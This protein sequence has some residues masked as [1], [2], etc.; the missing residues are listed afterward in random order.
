MAGLAQHVCCRAGVVD[1]GL[2]LLAGGQ[3][4]GELASEQAQAVGALEGGVGVATRGVLDVGVVVLFEGA[5]DHGAELGEEL[6][7]L[8]LGACEGKVGH[9]E[10]GGDDGGG[11][12]GCE[13][14]VHS[15]VAGPAWIRVRCVAPE[16]WLSA[17]R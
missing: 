2:A 16:C 17:P 8:A 9:V 4:H 14:G 11:G 13:N 6:L 1:V 5:L 3:V 7:D 10:F 12:A 15:L